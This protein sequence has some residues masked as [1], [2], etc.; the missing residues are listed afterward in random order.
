MFGRAVAAAVLIAGTGLMAM[1]PA[2]GASAPVSRIYSAAQRTC[3]DVSTTDPGHYFLDTYGHSCD[4]AASQSFT[5]TALSGTP[6]GT[7]EITSRSTGEC[8]DKYR[9]AIR[10]ESCIGSVPPDY[11]NAEWTLQRDGTS[12]H[13]YLF[14]WTP[15]VGTSSPE[16]VQVYPKPNGYPGPL[17]DLTECD[18]SQPDQI[19]TLTTAP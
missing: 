17:F 6:V 4:G 11:T 7:Y 1:T 3:L 8:L 15:S 10:Q 18:T 16:C 19:I 9:S 2:A 5:F 14:V 12:G 13:R